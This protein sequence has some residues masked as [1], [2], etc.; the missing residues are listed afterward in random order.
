MIEG[1]RDP[2]GDGWRFAVCVEGAKGAR[3]RKYAFGKEGIEHIL[4]G[5]SPSVTVDTAL[6]R[7]SMQA[8][9]SF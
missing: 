4:D 6:S 8:F 9:L 1:D 2:L 7:K 3:A 5:R